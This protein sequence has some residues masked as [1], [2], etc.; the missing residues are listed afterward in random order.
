MPNT[1][2]LSCIH[3]VAWN[4]LVFSLWDKEELP[5]ATLGKQNHA[6]DLTKWNRYAQEKAF[7]ILSRIFLNK[8]ILFIASS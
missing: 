3:C 7:P 5:T 8:V 2:K 1:F 4:G 6:R